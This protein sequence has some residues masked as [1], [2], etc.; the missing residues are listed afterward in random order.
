MSKGLCLPPG[1]PRLVNRNVLKEDIGDEVAE[2]AHGKNFPK[3]QACSVRISRP[4]SNYDFK[5][6]EESGWGE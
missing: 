3:F 5:S 6:E 1:S 4:S 2:Q